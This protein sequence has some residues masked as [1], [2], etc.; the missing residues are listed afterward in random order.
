MLEF[1]INLATVIIGNVLTLVVI[2]GILGLVLS[3][4][5]YG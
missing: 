1:A 3:K 4:K 5:L 2:G